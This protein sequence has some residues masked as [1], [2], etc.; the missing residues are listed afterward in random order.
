[1]PK[2][3]WKT[4]EICR[5]LPD[6]C[7]ISLQDRVEGTELPSAVWSIEVCAVFRRCP[8]CHIFYDYDDGNAP[9]HYMPDDKWVRRIT[10]DDGRDV[11][12]R[13]VFFASGPHAD[14]AKTAKRWLQD[15]DGSEHP[16]FAQ[17][18][19]NYATLLRKTGRDKY[20]VEAVKVE[21]RAK[22]I[23]AKRAEENPAD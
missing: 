18:L 10:E 14:I 11:R 23:R 1:M 20:N 2:P 9:D 17:R 12:G 15:L 8:L 16:D 13:L 22:A 4:C 3:A 21:A 19:E 7:G 6:F 5:D